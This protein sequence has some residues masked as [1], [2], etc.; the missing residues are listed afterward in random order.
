[1]EVI[2]IRIRI[3]D[4]WY[5]VPKS[6]KLDDLKRRSNRQSALSLHSAAADFLLEYLAKYEP[7]VWSVQTVFLLTYL[8]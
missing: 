7:V 8:T 6:M 3:E 1:M 2:H 5:L 4:Y